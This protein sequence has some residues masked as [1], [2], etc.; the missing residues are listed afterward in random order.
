MRMVQMYCHVH[1]ASIVFAGEALVSC[2]S[3]CIAR[4]YVHVYD[5]SRSPISGRRAHVELRLF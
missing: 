2:I 3:T 4:I 5:D 1:D